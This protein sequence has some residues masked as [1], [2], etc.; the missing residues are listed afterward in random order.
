[1]RTIEVVRLEKHLAQGVSVF[2]VLRQIFEENTRRPRVGKRPVV[3]RA[4]EYRVEIEAVAEI[5]G[6]QERDG[7]LHG[8]RVL[9]R[10]PVG[11]LHRD[12]PRGRFALRRSK[13]LR[14]GLRTLFRFQKRRTSALAVNP[15]RVHLGKMREQL[16]REHIVPPRERLHLRVKRFVRNV[17]ELV[18]PRATGARRSS[19]RERS[20]SWRQNGSWRQSDRDS[21]TLYISPRFES[22]LA[23]HPCVF[24]IRTSVEVVRRAKARHRAADG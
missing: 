15:A 1:M 18:A 21:H 11:V 9:Q 13:L 5:A 12:V 10:L 2:L 24:T 20:E 7:L 6:D 23:L 14:A 22:S 8:A 16:G 3:S 19:S 4:V 17:L